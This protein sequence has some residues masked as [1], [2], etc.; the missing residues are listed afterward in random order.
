MVF[1]VKY[2]NLKG[3]TVDEVFQAPNK[4]ILY[5]NLQNRGVLP[6][7]IL[8]QE[9]GPA[10]K[11]DI[12]TATRVSEDDG[13]R[14]IRIPVAVFAIVLMLAGVPFGMFLMRK[15]D[16]PRAEAMPETK[17][18]SPK[19]S[20]QV[21]Q[22]ERTPV[23]TKAQQANTVPQ[24]ERVPLAAKVQETYTAPPAVRTPQVEVEPIIRAP[25]SK[26]G[27]RRKP[28]EP[29][30]GVQQ[31]T[32]SPVAG[33]PNTYTVVAGDTIYSIAKRF[34]GKVSAWKAIRDANKSVI[35]ADNRV[36]PGD[37]ITLP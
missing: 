32:A 34:Y 8:E 5:Y 7:E 24:V 11:Q 29:V 28:G 9:D 30:V 17:G 10:V 15:M 3:K 26:P 2:R 14:G 1:R 16:A 13:K 19:V 23:A 33:R 12:K 20:E 35:S 25:S 37:T 36:H 27:G 22:V 4:T 21:P 6:I 18:E 31:Q